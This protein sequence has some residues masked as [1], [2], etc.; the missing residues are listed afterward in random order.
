VR[1]TATS[2]A[3]RPVFVAESS[4]A[5]KDIPKAA[6]LRWHGGDCRPHCPACAA[7]LGR[8]WWTDDRVRAAR[9]I[10][11]ADPDTRALLGEVQAAQAASRATDAAVTVATPEGL[12]HYPFQRAGIAYALARPAVLFGDEPGLGKT[13]QA[14]GVIE[15]DPTIR[16]ALVIC[17]A[18]LKINW[19]RE[20]ERWMVRPLRVQVAN[21]DALTVPEP[22]DGGVS[23]V[24]VNYD[25]LK[26]HAAALGATPW[27]IIVID[28]AHYCKNP[29]AQRTQG[30]K[31]LAAQARRRLLLTGTPIPNKPIELFPLL[32]ILGSELAKNWWY[33]VK[34]Y[35]AAHQEVVGGRYGRLV[36]NMDG[37]SHLDELQERLR[38]EV[39]VRRL[40]RDVLTELPEKI[41][42]VVELAANGNQRLLD[43]EGAV[44]RRHADAEGEAAADVELAAAA[45]GGETY[46]RA[47]ARL[48]ELRRVAF[49]EIAALRHRTAIAKVPQ[50]I[51]YVTGLLDGGTEQLVVFA[52]H[53][54]VI[55]AIQAALDEAG[56]VNVRLTGEDDM[57]TRQ[58]AVDRFQADPSCRVF[59]GSITAAGVG[60]TLTAASTVVFA[61][62]DWVPGNV[63]QAE[64]RLHRIGQTDV[65]HVVHLVL[66]RSIDA[67]MAHILVAK[68]AVAD[69]ALDADTTIEF[70]ELVGVIEK[71]ARRSEAARKAAPAAEATLRRSVDRPEVRAAIS[72]A[73][74]LLAGVCDGAW[75]R[76]GAGFNKYDARIG[77]ALANLAE[78]TEPQAWLGYKVV[79]KYR[80]QLSPALY[81]II[82]PGTKEE[83]A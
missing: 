28:E 58:A 8:V 76:D 23:M 29:K 59:V 33:F 36:W 51:D 37:A 5:E 65:V 26:K 50:V 39:M 49:T 1:L 34:R 80:G 21:G 35:C 55:A 32:E 83:Q 27:D 40:K 73:L 60:L 14:L 68:Q 61:E 2:G 54:D 82:F 13:L 66:D 79:R 11:Y 77:H 24:V 52:H 43:E 70:R 71:H 17:P 30:V 19:R 18:S 22:P 47:V 64:D 41:R 38:A 15:G 69:R 78:L 42:Q 6:G 53:H 46:E 4:Y 62:L 10:E 81:G 7:G 25:I 67:R 31:A 3:D 12:A 75:Q 48:T 44:L 16:R 74:Q 20:A 45:G 9:L 72:E 63:T 56:V 57:A